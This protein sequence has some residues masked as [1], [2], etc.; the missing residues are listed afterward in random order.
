MGCDVAIKPT[1]D[2]FSLPQNIWGKVSKKVM[3]WGLSSRVNVNVQKSG[4]VKLDLSA[5]NSDLDTF[6][7]LNSSG[8]KT[9]ITYFF[10]KPHCI[11]VQPWFINRKRSGS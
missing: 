5:K 9:N 8:G 10:G 1:L 3:G 2:V 6:V 11:S 7:K 4:N